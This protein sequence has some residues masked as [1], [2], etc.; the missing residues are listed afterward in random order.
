VFDVGVKRGD[1]VGLLCE[2]ITHDER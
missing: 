1:W 2:V